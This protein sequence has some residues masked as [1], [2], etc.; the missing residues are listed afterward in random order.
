MV[1]FV[2]FVQQSKISPHGQV[3]ISCSLLI[4]FVIIKLK[5]AMVIMFML[6]SKLW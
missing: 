6:K 4:L 3:G 5:I 2:T 1:Q